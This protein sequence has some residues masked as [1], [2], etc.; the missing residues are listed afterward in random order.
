MNECEQFELDLLKTIVFI[1]LLSSHSLILACGKANVG[2]LVDTS[3]VPS[4]KFVQKLVYNYI[5]LFQLQG[6]TVTIYAYGPTQRRVCDW[7]SFGSP[8][9]I[10]VS[11]EYSL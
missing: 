5:R 4:R 6:T 1:L 11:T 10:Q 3:S 2:F 9:D 7:R 8:T